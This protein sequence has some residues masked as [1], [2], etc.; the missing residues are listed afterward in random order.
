MQPR[1]EALKD[2]LDEWVRGRPEG[3]ELSLVRQMRVAEVHLIHV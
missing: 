1:L 2:I 3:S